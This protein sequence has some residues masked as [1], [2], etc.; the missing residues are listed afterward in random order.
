MASHTHCRIH[1]LNE[2]ASMEIVDIG[3]YQQIQPKHFHETFTLGLVT[4]G[5]GVFEQNN[6]TYPVFKGSVI[7]T[8]PG[9]VHASCATDP[10]GSRHFVLYPSAQLLATILDGT[11][12]SDAYF[13][14]PVIR[15][16]QAEVVMQELIVTLLSNDLQL[17]RETVFSEAVHYLFGRYLTVDLGRAAS[18]V[19]PSA[20]L[21]ARARDYLRENFR[22][23]IALEKLAAIAQCS[24]F[25]LIE[26]FN[27]QIGMPPHSYQIQ[28][29]L[30][31]AQHL[32]RRGEPIVEVAAE[33][34]FFDQSHL[35]RHFKRLVGLPPSYYRRPNRVSRPL[36]FSAF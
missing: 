22:D 26:Q 18:L 10:G 13:P 24:R 20:R 36:H 6:E 16:R 33:C 11:D 28:L 4:R 34:G 9:T 35:T 12:L 32:L 31:L 19:A 1:R 15:E 8:A 7:S 14:N 23:N 29:R 3:G 21:I 5:S 25:Q 17:Q 2:F 30:Q 27:R